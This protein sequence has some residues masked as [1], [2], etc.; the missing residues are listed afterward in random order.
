LLGRQLTVE[1][2]GTFI[3]VF[4]VRLA[5][6][7]EGAGD[8]APL[9]IGSALMVMVFAGGHISGAHYN[10]AVSFAALLAGKLHLR[11]TVCY[12]LT[13]LTA[14]ALAALL[15]RAFAGPA[16]PALLGSDW[17][18]LIGEL[19]FTLAL[20]YV[21]LNVTASKATEGNSFFGLAIGFTVVTGA[22]AVGKTTGGAFNLAVALGGSIT[23]ALR[24]SD[25]WI[26]LA[27]SLLGGAGAARLFAYLHPTYE[28]G[29][30]PFLSQVRSDDPD[31]RGTGAWQ[32][33]TP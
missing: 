9:A 24:W 8:L 3:L 7:S 23:G 30:R 32:G 22:F 21:V 33:N 25:A 10:P 13:Q 20:A 17:K 12:V 29:D 1:F 4:T 27:A 2:I 19:I 18:I 15:G 26:Y 6:S 5:T 31:S 28:E 14:G 16:T 11:Q